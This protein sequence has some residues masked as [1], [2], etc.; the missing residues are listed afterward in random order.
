MPLYWHV[1]KQKQFLNHDDYSLSSQKNL[2]NILNFDLRT[3]D[4]GLHFTN[5]FT[6]KILLKGI[7]KYTAFTGLKLLLKFTEKFQF[8]SVLHGFISEAMNSLHFLIKIVIIQR[9]SIQ[10]S[11][12][13]I[14]CSELVKI[15][16]FYF[17]IYL[18][19]KTKSS[20]RLEGP[21]IL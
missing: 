3:A 17:I 20:I 13:V 21:T 15:Y 6:F 19:W 14:P 16:L 9:N 1:L 12:S 4:L 5:Y 7:F 8:I 18:I 2:W 10:E 11:D